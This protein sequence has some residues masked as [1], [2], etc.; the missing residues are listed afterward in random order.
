MLHINNQGH[1]PLDVAKTNE[2]KQCIIKHPWYRRRQLMLMRP[3]ADYRSNKNHRMTA[4]AWILTAKE[5]GDGED[6]EL[7][8]LKRVVASFL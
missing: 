5:T 6:V 3:H 1:T 8:D 2:I 7:F 4:L